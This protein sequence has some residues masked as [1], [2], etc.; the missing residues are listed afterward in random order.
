MNPRPQV[1]LPQPRVRRELRSLLPR[2]VPCA[3]IVITRHGEPVAVIVSTSSLQW[4]ER[5][6]AELAMVRATGGA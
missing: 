4:L 6:R 5:L 3:D 2:T 1:R